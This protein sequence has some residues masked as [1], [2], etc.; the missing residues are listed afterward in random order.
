MWPE[1]GTEVNTQC[2]QPAQLQL[3][4]A[5]YQLPYPAVFMHQVVQVQKSSMHAVRARSDSMA[6]DTLA[7]P[8][9]TLSLHTAVTAG[10]CDCLQDALQEHVWCCVGG[11]H[12]G[13]GPA[14]R[15]LGPE[16]DQQ[17]AAAGQ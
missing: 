17:P 10:C 2:C 12:W 6:A 16:G 11:W 4:A 3:S 14:N 9:T 15:T 1:V 13:S 8:V 7:Y 5:S